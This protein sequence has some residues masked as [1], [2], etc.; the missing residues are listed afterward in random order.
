MASAGRYTCVPNLRM[1]SNVDTCLFAC[2]IVSSICCATYMHIGMIA[3][4]A[5]ATDVLFNPSRTGTTE[6]LVCA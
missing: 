2:P 1:C 4:R 6:V 5:T 3:K